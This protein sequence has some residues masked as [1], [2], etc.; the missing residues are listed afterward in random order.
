MGN[1]LARPRT[2]GMIAL[3]AAA[4]L[5]AAVTVAVLTSGGTAGAATAAP[6]PGCLTSRDLTDHRYVTP[7]IDWRQGAADFFTQRPLC[8]GVRLLGSGAAYG[9]AIGAK[10]SGNGHPN[11]PRWPQYRV[12]VTSWQPLAGAAGH[13]LFRFP[14]VVDQCTQT[15]VAIWTQGLPTAWPTALGR[16]GLPQPRAIGF[17]VGTG[18]G[19]F[20]A[21]TV[22][23][24]ATCKAGS[25][26]GSANTAFTI[27]NSGRYATVTAATLAVDGRPV[28]RYPHLA[29][30]P[31]QSLRAT[32]PL[33]D[34]P[35][36]YRL[37]YTLRFSGST[38][39]A[40]SGSFDVRC[41]PAAT[42]QVRVTCL[43]GPQQT[44]QLQDRNTTRYRHVII[45][46]TASG[47]RLAATTVNPHSSGTVTVTWAKTDLV[48]V[49]VQNQLGAHHTD[50]GGRV[51]AGTV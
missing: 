43:C 45:L 30:R 24:R 1:L 3:G 37:D 6:A 38:T 40:V 19:C 34:G 51:L 21:P 36:R 48:R 10:P 46:V 16:P 41:P 29:I 2:R 13:H 7:N 42:I 26:D 28:A 50:I 35:H 39:G 49:L 44:A 20:P 18:Q 27:K 11:V 4:A 31:G 8:H 15:D 25:C 23:V 9:F 47:R 22:S 14:P 17:F 12:R 33:R 32:I 5:T